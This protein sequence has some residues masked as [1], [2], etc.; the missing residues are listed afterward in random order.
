MER[1]WN[2]LLLIP[3]LISFVAFLLTGQILYTAAGFI[4]GYG[5]L[6]IVRR[7]LLPPHLHEAVQKF[8]K[9]D[10]E[11]A[12]ILARQAIAARPSRW[13]PYYLQSLIH[14]GLTQLEQAEASAREALTRNPDSDS[15]HAVLGQILYAQG[16]YAPAKD[17]YV[18]AA[19]IRS[20]DAMNQY[21]AGAAYFRLAEYERAIPRLELATKLGLDD[22]ALALLAHYYLARSFELTDQPGK[23]E[24]AAEAMHEHRSG[25]ADLKRGVTEA[26]P[27]PDLAHLRDDVNA[28]AIR[29]GERNG[30]AD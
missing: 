22:A 8:Q 28:L 13:E 10:L 11:G 19:R 7:R 30:T 1:R 3:I 21:Q 27:Y 2:L 12:L 16:R 25:L 24:S 5:L 23:A 15:A 18:I 9:G 17:E 14:F 20:R 26:A 6:L 4:A 29:L